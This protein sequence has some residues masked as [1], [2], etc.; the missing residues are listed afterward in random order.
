MAAIA[1][2]DESLMNYS[3]QQLIDCDRAE[4]Q[5][6]CSGGWMYEA[7]DYIS[8][9]GILLEDDYRM[10]DRRQNHCDI[11]DR[12]LLRF[13]HLSGIGYVEEDGQTNENLRFLL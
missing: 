5:E 10:Y 1:G 9:H 2:F 4:G 11:S 3:V 6:A 7:F 13:K 8:K 12:D